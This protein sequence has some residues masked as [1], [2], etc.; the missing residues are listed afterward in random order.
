MLAQQLCTTID[1]QST[2]MLAML[3]DFAAIQDANP[4]VEA[5]SSPAPAANT[6]A[7][8]D[9]Q[10]EMMRILQEMHQVYGR[11][12]RGF[13]GRGGKGGRGGR[14]YGNRSRNRRTPDNANLFVVSR[15]NIIIHT[16]DATTFLGTARGKHPDKMMLRNLTTVV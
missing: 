13:A 7:Q 1:T 16:V 15:T 2:E 4:P 11:G 6:V 9:V 12:R 14:G 10:L 5:P 3:Q 8:T